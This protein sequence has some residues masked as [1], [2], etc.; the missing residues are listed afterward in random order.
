MR[1]AVAL[2]FF[3]LAVATASVAED[4]SA[5]RDA[6]DEYIGAFVMNQHLAS[7]ERHAPAVADNF[8]GQV[9]TLQSANEAV[10]RKV[11][12]AAFNWRLPGGRAISEILTQIQESTDAYYSGLGGDVGADH[13]EKM[14]VTLMASN[15]TFERARDGQ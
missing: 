11:E 4:S 15:Y 14:L 5:S 2:S 8:R 1:L 12:A 7:C 10:M 13:C 3:A 9:A 6:Y